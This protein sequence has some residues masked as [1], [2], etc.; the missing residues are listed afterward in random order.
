[1]VWDFNFRWDMTDREVVDFTR[2][3]ALKVNGGGSDARVW[4]PAVK[5]NF[6]VNLFYNTTSSISSLLGCD[7]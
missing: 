1:M 6:S 2:M 5:G 7:W 3:M 4:K